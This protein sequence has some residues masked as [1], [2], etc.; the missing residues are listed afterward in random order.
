MSVKTH[1]HGDQRNGNQD[2]MANIVT[3]LWAGKSAVQ[4]L[5]GTRSLAS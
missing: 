3:R 4:F 2:N 5:V 1:K